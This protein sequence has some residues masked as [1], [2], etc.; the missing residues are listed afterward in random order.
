MRRAP[1]DAV[2]AS[3]LPSSSRTAKQREKILEFQYRLEKLDREEFRN[4]FTLASD[5]F[6]AVDQAQGFRYDKLRIEVSGPTQPHLTLIV[7][8]Q[9]FSN[10]GFDTDWSLE[11]STRADSHHYGSTELWSF[12]AIYELTRSYLQKPRTIVL[13][14]VSATSDFQ[15]QSVGV[16]MQS[17]EI[18]QRMMGVITK[19]D[20]A[21]SQDD[22][23]KSIDLARNEELTLGFG[24]HVVRTSAM[25]KKTVR[26]NTGT[27]KS[28]DSSP[29]VFG[30][31]FQ[32]KILEL[33]LSGKS[34]ANVSSSLS[35]ETFP[36]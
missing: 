30:P 32:A 35:S 29:P 36:Y 33:S 11:G 12:G 31:G 34:C 25:K 6:E 10:R 28:D 19:P 8:L 3:I 14:V 24:W 15:V 22:A 13:A 9:C 4:L 26:R 27:R 5:H 2:Y 1:C 21:L 18:A 23:L 7:S 20:G 17:F 16:L